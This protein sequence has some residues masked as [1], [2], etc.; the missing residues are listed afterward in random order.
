MASS[1]KNKEWNR[2]IKSFS[3]AIAGLKSA[4]LSEGN[5]RIHVFMSIIVLA[6]GFILQ[7]GRIEFIVVLLLI[8][9]MITIELLNTAIEKVVD[10]VTSEFHPLAKLAKD[11]AAGAVLIYA[12][13]SV[14]IGVI[15]FFPYLLMWL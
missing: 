10:L 6:L 15:I 8:G 13:T 9:G 3:Y 11:I 1:D 14:I 5:L 12:I 2:L 7:I 4:F